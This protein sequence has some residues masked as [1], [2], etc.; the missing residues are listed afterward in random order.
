MR[1]VKTH[2]VTLETEAF[3]KKNNVH[4]HAAHWMTE[5]IRVQRLKLVGEIANIPTT[6][7]RAQKQRSRE[8]G[9]TGRLDFFD[10]FGCKNPQPPRA[11]ALI[12]KPIERPQT[13]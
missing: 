12:L 8:H 7:E 3:I 5:P 10:K 4:A 1:N 6:C 2:A 11:E 9:L 13:Q